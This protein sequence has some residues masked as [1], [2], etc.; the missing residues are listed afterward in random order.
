MY[1]GWKIVGVTFLTNFI[2]VGFVFYSFGTFLTTLT[3]EFETDRFR[4]AAALT[5]MNVVVGLVAPFLGRIADGGHIRRMMC[6]GAVMMGGGFLLLSQVNHLW[7]FY[8][9]LAVLVGIGNAMIGMVPS[10]TLVANWFIFR[11][12]MA[13]GISTMGISLSGMVMAPLTGIMISA[14]GW[15]WTFAIFGVTAAVLVLPVAWFFVVQRPEDMGLAPDGPGYAPLRGNGGAGPAEES[16]PGGGSE[17]SPWGFREAFSDPNFHAITLTIALTFCSNGAMLTH[18]VARTEDLGFTLRDGTL[19]LAC[20]AGFGVVGK[21][22]F[23][24][25]ADRMNKKIALWIC[26]GVQ[27]IGVVLF[28]FFSSYGALLAIAGFFGFG[29]GGLVP[30]WGSLVGAVFGRHIFGR[31]MGMMSPYMIPFQSFGIPFAGYVFVKTGSYDFAF[32]IFIGIYVAAMCALFFVKLPRA[33]PRDD[34]PHAEAI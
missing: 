23:G 31:V 29:M 30:L 7:Q 34:A 13:L 32:K 10:S 15:R 8:V 2:S 25:I 27:L 14:F 3:E 22:F 24:W 20:C 9:L 28:L 33:D 5:V 1:Y 19:V 18:M 21:I 11:R 6:I 17:A 16:L 12:G 4:I 26:I